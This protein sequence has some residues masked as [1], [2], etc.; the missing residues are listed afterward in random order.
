MRNLILVRIQELREYHKGFGKT[1]MRWMN[2]E[3]N[4]DHI[5]E[6]RFT[7]LSDEKLLEEFERIVRRHYTQM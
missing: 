4:G 6:A 5:S 1:T 2:F 7:N 3:V